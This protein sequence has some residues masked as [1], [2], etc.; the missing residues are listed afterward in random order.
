MGQHE[1]LGELVEVVVEHPDR[2][3]RLERAGAEEVAEPFSGF[4]VH[5]QDRVGGVEVFPLEPADRLELVVSLGV[6]AQRFHAQGFAFM[7]TFLIEQLADDMHTD[8]ASTLSHATCDFDL[9][10][11]GPDQGLRGWAAGGAIEEDLVEVV[12]DLGV[13]I[14]PP[15]PPPAGLADLRSGFGGEILEVVLAVTN[16]LGIDA[17]DLGDVLDPAVTQLGRLDRRIPSPIILR[18]EW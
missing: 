1:S 14:E 13:L 11:V 12:G 15:S 8:K 6:A 3:S 16:G 17:Q 4:Q 7:E 18:K 10:Q 2:L 9:G 5:A